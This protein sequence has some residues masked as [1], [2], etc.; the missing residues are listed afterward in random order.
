MA[1]TTTP[2]SSSLPFGHALGA[3]GRLLTQ[4]ISLGAAAQ[5][6][7]ADRQHA[8]APRGGASVGHR[9]M[10]RELYTLLEHHPASRQMMRHLDVIERTLRRTGIEAVEALPVKVLDRGLNELEALVW[11]WSQPG[12]AEVRSRLAVTVKRRRHE[13]NAP[14]AASQLERYDRYDRAMPTIDAEV[15][16]VSHEL[17]EEMERSWTG[18]MP[19]QR[20]E[21]TVDAPRTD[22]A[23][24]AAA[25]A[26]K[27]AG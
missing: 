27:S 23:V 2:A 3:I 18:R 7:R 1:Q 19:D 5:H 22:A 6:A 15:Q 17:F 12:L 16:E 14:D 8:A 26:P 4:P 13:A 11:D 10:R 20:T 24:D 21:P 25:A 9:Q